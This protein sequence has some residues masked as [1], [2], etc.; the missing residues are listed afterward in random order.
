MAQLEVI[1]FAFGVL[2]ISEFSISFYSGFVTMNGKVGREKLKVYPPSLKCWVKTT[3][4]YQ[5]FF[6]I[7]ILGGKI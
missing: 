2:H 5:I 7:F 3:L 6:L 4:P 1:R